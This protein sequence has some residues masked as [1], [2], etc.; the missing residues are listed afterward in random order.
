MPI[1]TSIFPYAM[2]LVT[3]CS[4]SLSKLGQTCFK[5]NEGFLIIKLAF[6]TKQ[7]NSVFPAFNT[8]VTTEACVCPAIVLIRSRSF[9]PLVTR[10]KRLVQASVIVVTLE[11]SSNNMFTG[12]PSMSTLAVR[13][14]V[15]GLLYE[16]KY[17]SI[18]VS[19]TESLT[20]LSSEETSKFCQSEPFAFGDG[21]GVGP[22]VLAPGFCW[23]CLSYISCTS[24]RGCMLG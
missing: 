18:D 24:F 20:Q 7:F 12:S 4:V 11:P 13:N 19:S 10:A 21:P 1:I 15:V 22:L 6:T 2:F 16:E 3:S 8:V 5:S 23:R 14:K 9:D 17:M